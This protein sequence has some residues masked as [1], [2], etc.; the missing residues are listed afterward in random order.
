MQ[1]DRD[2]R[3]GPVASRSGY[4]LAPEPDQP[5]PRPIATRDG[6]W[7]RHLV[8]GW[9]ELMDMATPI[10]AQ[11]HGYC[12]A[13]GSELAAAC[14]LLYVAE[15]ATIGYPPVR[16][17][18]SPDLMWQPWFMGMRR[19]ME[20]LLTGDSMTGRRGR[21]GRVRQ[22]RVPRRP[23]R[24]RGARRSPSGSR[25]SRATSSPS[26]S[27]RCTARWRRMGMRTGLRATHRAPGAG[28]APTL[29]E[30]VHAEAALDGREGRGRGSRRAV[31]RRPGTPEPDRR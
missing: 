9:F 2:P 13:G 16:T 12:L 4:D 26:T 18:S 25:R 31:R 21:R 24:R 1:R 28:P 17:M 14:D 29:V 27:A 11:V 5:L 22:P 3:R 20:A 10:I 6:F 15:D 8:E 23:A 7:S 19:A 30:G